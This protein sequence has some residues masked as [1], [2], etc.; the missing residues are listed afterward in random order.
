[1]NQ[2]SKPVVLNGPLWL[3]I[4]QYNAETGRR[5]E[6]LRMAA[7]EAGDV[8]VYASTQ[9]LAKELGRV[10]QSPSVLPSEIIRLV[11]ELTAA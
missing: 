2:A 7:L 1:M 6:E 5:I 9:V 4:K 8:S 3:Y 10:T 11:S